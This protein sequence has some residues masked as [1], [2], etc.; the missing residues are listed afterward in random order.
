MNG[1]T[2]EFNGM[3]SQNAIL[4][5]L[6]CQIIFNDDH[7]VLFYPKRSGKPFLKYVKKYNCDFVRK[8]L[9]IHEPIIIE[10]LSEPRIFLATYIFQ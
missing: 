1:Q 9:R 7:C 3:P 5:I 10:R 8:K 2:G 6:K 4:L